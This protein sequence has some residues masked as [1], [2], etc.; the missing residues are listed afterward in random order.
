MSDVK[1]M[2]DSA[3]PDHRREGIYDLVSKD[4]GQH[5]PYTKRYRQIAQS[6][7]DFTVRAAAV[8]ACNWSRDKSA[9]PVFIA[10]LNDQSESVRWEAAK[11]L[12]NV[13]DPSAIDPLIRAINSQTESR[14][15]KIAATDALRHYRNL[16]AARALVSTLNGKDFGV[17]WQ[18]RHSLL[19][20]TG[21]D[22]RYDERAWL[23][24]LT[25]A[26][27]PVG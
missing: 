10:A 27:K 6:D 2:E 21:A 19:A 15:V 24:Y 9:V 20:M 13:P 16:T 7:S 8:R 25:G 17:A 1:K 26:K 12:A 5:E 4:F 3:S 23:E 18:A 14:N 11:G 22:L